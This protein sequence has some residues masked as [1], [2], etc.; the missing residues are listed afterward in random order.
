MDSVLDETLSRLRLVDPYWQDVS[1]QDLAAMLHV[2]WRNAGK[3]RL[4][5][6]HEDPLHAAQAVIAWQDVVV[7][8]VHAAVAQSQSALL[9]S[10]EWKA[11]TDE[12]A[13]AASQVAAL[14][15]IR[16]QL[17]GWHVTLSDRPAGQVLE[18]SER[19]LLRQPFDQTQQGAAWQPLMAVFP[20]AGSSNDA[21]IAWIDQA[22]PLLAAEIQVLQARLDRMEQ[23]ETDLAARYT[24]AS[25][26]SLGLSAELLVQKISDRKLE[27]TAVRSSGVAILVG[28]IVGLIVW[29][30]FW[31][32]KPA[33]RMK[34]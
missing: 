23:S 1:R 21:Y 7:E 28:A 11:V 24:A 17:T 13:R 18:P 29:A 19:L 10:D 16:R 14:D 26:E 27:Q 2:Y 33:V 30:L 3:W 22:L 31:L 9:L 15:Q 25:N 20:P 8:Q 32:V 6:E 34:A 4:V 12:K 5:A